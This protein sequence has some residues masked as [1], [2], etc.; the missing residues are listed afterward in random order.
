MRVSSFLEKS[1]CEVD[2]T[3]Q[4]CGGALGTGGS[5]IRECLRQSCE[6]SD[7]KTDDLQIRMVPG[8]IPGEYH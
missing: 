1:P 6:L 7:G 5:C 8:L 2:E 4:W 3:K